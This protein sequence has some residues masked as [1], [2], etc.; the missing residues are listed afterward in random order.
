M[1][2][3][4]DN[5]KI[6]PFLLFFLMGNQVGVGAMG[7]QR[8]IARSAGYDGWISVIIAGLS[9]NLVVW[10]MYK[11]MEN[12]NGDINDTHFTVLGKWI[13]G[14]FNLIWFTYFVAMSVI[15]LRTYIEVVQVWMFPDLKTLW[16]SAAFLA[17]CIY[18]LYGGFRTVVGIAFFA[19]VLPFYIIFIFGLSLPFCDFR[20]FLPILDHSGHGLL[21]A[22]QN[23]SLTYTGYETILFF[24]PFINNQE[25]SK[26]WMHMG[27]AFTTLLY[28]YITIIS[29]SFF[30]EE[31][32]VKEIWVT[33]SIFKIIHLPVVERFEYIGI[34]NWC[35]I[36]L[37]NVCTYIWCAS[38]ILKRNFKCNQRIGVILICMVCLFC[39]PFLKTRLQIASLDKSLGQ[40]GFMLNYIYIPLLCLAAILMKKI[41]TAKNSAAAK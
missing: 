24:Y 41:K 5:R 28:T 11:I 18:I 25:K 2:P 7:F 23:M 31:Q 33:L 9:T 22:S 32:L 35:L 26:R 34:A 39:M 17:L 36:I 1:Q 4:P 37:P 16:F 14:F 6:S 29:F 38:R 10:F 12:S 20:H 15:I 13:G 21:L 27:L 3:V 40:F 8:I 19:F 30:T